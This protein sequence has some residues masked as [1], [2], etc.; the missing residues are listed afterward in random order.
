MAKNTKHTIEDIRTLLETSDEAVE[1]GLVKL[2]Q[3]QTSDE[4]A[5]G[6][7]KHTNGVGFNGVDSQFL[8]DL[9]QTIMGIGEWEGR[10]GRMHARTGPKHLTEG[11]MFHARKA[12]MK[13]AGQLTAIANG[14]EVVPEVAPAPKPTEVPY[15]LQSTQD[16]LASA[17]D[18]DKL[19]KALASARTFKNEMLQA[20]INEVDK[21]YTQR[22]EEW[23][24]GV[25]AVTQILAEAREVVRTLE[26]Y[27]PPQPQP[28]K[29]SKPTLE[30]VF[31]TG[32]GTS[33]KAKEDAMKHAKGE[34]VEPTP[35][36]DP[37]CPVC[38]KPITPK[39]PKAQDYDE[40]GKVTLHIWCKPKFNPNKPA[41]IYTAPMKSAG[42]TVVGIIDEL[43]QEAKA[44][45]RAPLTE[46]EK[47][48]EA[49]D[50]AWFE[51]NLPRMAG[52]ATVSDKSVKQS[53]EEW[54]EGMVG[55]KFTKGRRGW[56]KRTTE[57][58]TTRKDLA[59]KVARNRTA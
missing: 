5:T 36:S 11:Q 30:E 17:P 50:D 12:I 24:K 33:A 49:E 1:R 2:Y 29:A 34:A 3:L 53:I 7:T 43:Q 51:A 38:H 18:A 6:A 47:A 44:P 28:K 23:A 22:N 57:D 56:S 9:A 45:K 4:Q 26:A 19:T 39:Q 54:A 14:E 32:Q 13:Y 8:S 10:D 21:D 15:L 20:Y 58:N 46:A 16:F 40:S 37:I 59:E 35:T 41:T 52:T 31:E 27:T 55:D 42:R 25:A 48:Q